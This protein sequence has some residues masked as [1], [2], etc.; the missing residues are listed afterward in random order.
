MRSFFLFFLILYIPGL[1]A[2]Q[3]IPLYKTQAP[4]M[5]P[6]PSEEKYDSVKQHAF[7]VTNPSLTIY[8][9][10]KEKATGAAVIV[11][12]GGG[13]GMLVM[14]TEGH[15]IAQ[16]FADHGVAAFAL[17]YRLPDEKQMKDKSI[18]PLQ[19]AQRAIQLVRQRAGEWNI[20]TA[21]IGIMGFSAG[22]HLASTA[23]THFD[24]P[25]ISNPQHTSLR[26]N[27][28]ILVYP[29]VSMTDKLGHGG[30]RRNLL[31]K[32]PSTEKIK[33]FSN[34]LQVTS[35][36][37]PAFLIHAGDDKVVDVDNSIMLYEALRHHKVPAEMHIY[38]KG[39]H[40]F[41][42]QWPHDE[43]LGLCLKWMKSSGYLP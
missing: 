34:E 14:G 28:M 35:K 32:N 33:L 23:G 18:A 8:L 42:L 25:V 3:I 5:L 24:Y 43:W 41:I 4:G 17:K 13:Y 30:S 39:D 37:S 6:V 26:P 27:F 1:Y 21:R 31:G 12:P 29:V 36:T 40:G 7:K 22:G 38:P 19:D 15:A 2:Q 11:C 10:A 16:Y 9:P 20:D